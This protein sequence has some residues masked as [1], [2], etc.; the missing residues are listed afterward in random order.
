MKKS[1]FQYKINNYKLQFCLLIFALYLPIVAYATTALVQVDSGLETVN[2]LEGTLVL[3]PGASVTDIYTG[4]SAILIWVVPPVYDQETDSIS[5]AGL[6]PGGFKGQYPLFTLSGDFN[7]NRVSFRNVS[8]LRNDGLGTQV[9][10]RLTLASTEIAEDTVPPELFAPIIA[11]SP[12]IFDNQYFIS[13]VTQDKGTG[14]D[15]FEAVSTWI[16]KPRDSAW[17][18]VESPVVLSGTTLFKKIHIRA[19]DKS[20]N[21]RVV[22]T[23]GPYHYYFLAFGVIILLCVLLFIRRFWSPHSFSS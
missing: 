6:T 4:N 14:V 2:A 19:I 10:V 17:V 8:G 5:F 23:V 21:Y 22:S 15:R 18:R 13:F 9:P 3:P 1:K 11:R 16:L 12:D 20:E 7:L